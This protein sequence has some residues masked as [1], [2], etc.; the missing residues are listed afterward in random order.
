MGGKEGG[1]Q[2][3]EGCIA[4][5]APLKSAAKNPRHPGEQS[6]VVTLTPST[7]ICAKTAVFQPYRNNMYRKDRAD[8]ALSGCG[9]GNMMSFNNLWDNKM[10]T[11][12][13]LACLGHPSTQ[14]EL[15]LVLV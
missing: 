1:R 3:N 15:Y 12:P 9:G 2:R 11:K 8:V 13:E 5:H 6:R 4:R 7:Y 10:Y 14:C